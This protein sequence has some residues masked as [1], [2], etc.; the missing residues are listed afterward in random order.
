MEQKNTSKYFP[1]VGDGSGLARG[2]A[3]HA[4]TF[5]GGSNGDL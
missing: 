3:G 4:V 2:I 5:S 1:T